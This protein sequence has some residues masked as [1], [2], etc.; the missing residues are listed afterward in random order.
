MALCTKDSGSTTTT[1]SYGAPK[2]WHSQTSLQLTLLNTADTKDLTLTCLQLIQ[3]DLRSS[4]HNTTVWLPQ[5]YHWC[6]CQRYLWRPY[7][8]S[9]FLRLLDNL[10]I[11]W[12]RK[13]KK[14]T[15]NDQRNTKNQVG[16]TKPNKQ[17]VRCDPLIPNQQ[18]RCTLNILQRMSKYKQQN[19]LVI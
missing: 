16:R 17:L 2:N 15:V 7:Q 13:K 9:C 18:P 19:P 5:C 6:L 10:Q 12:K 11:I 3:L 1:I 8:G 14:R 4:E